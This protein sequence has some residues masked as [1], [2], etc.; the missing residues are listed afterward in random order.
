MRTKATV[1][2]TAAGGIV[3]QGIMKSLKLSNIKK[4]HPVMYEIV[5]TDINAQA[6]GLYRSD[7]GILVPSPSAS[8]Y[9]DSIIK[10]CKEQNVQA[11]FVGSDEELFP[12][13]LA[14]KK[15]EKETGATV[16]IN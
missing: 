10:I 15:I 3:S 4:Y 5:A 16:L 6:A 14:K 12:V 9:I 8:D 2:V 11:I 7:I 13:A 1:L